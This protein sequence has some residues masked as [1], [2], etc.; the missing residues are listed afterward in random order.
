MLHLGAVI[1]ILSNDRPVYED[2]E[3]NAYLG[4]PWRVPAMRW[5]TGQGQRIVEADLSIARKIALYERPAGSEDG[6]WTRGRSVFHLFNIIDIDFSIYP[7]LVFN[8]IVLR[9]DS[10]VNVKQLKCLCL[11]TINISLYPSISLGV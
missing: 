8:Q 10:Y 2:R 3:Y 6:G 5:D 4:P 11:C 1:L 7:T 9:N